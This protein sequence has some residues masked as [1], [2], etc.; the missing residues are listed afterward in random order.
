MTSIPADGRHLLGFVIFVVVMALAIFRPRGI[1]E[2]WAAVG[3]AAAMLALG[4]VSPPDLLRVLEETSGVLVFLLGMMAVAAVLDVAGVFEWAASVALRLSRCSGRRLLVSV[5]VLGAVVT[6]L[7]SLDVTVLML[8]PVVYTTVVAHQIDALPYLYACTFVANTGS[9][10]FPMSN[11]TNLLIVDGLKVP[12]WSYTAMM[13]VPDVAAVTTT[14]LVFLWVFRDRLPA[15][16][17]SMDRAWP[18]PPS[19]RF[20]RVA[21]GVCGLMLG[22][23]FA[24]G[25]AGWPLWPVA[26]G[27]GTVLV[28]AAWSIGRQDLR[29]LGRRIS[30]PL[31]PF[32][33]GIASTVRGIQHA[34][35]TQTLGRFVLGHAG[36]S[37]GSGLLIGT[38]SAL[39]A[40]VFT[41]VPMALVM[42]AALHQLPPARIGLLAGAVLAGTNIGPAMTPVGSLATML[43]LAF[44]R[45]Q[46]VN[47][48]V[49]DYL[50]V[51][52]LT[53]PCA[54]AAAL[55]TLFLQI[56]LWGT[57]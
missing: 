38:V 12:F 9:L 17:D 16:L 14:V 22:G 10:L 30:W 37:L 28:G 40:N 2:A 51:G 49:G 13:V 56:S 5:F 1:H 41:N 44:A 31:L 47:V 19:D 11:L 7:L 25:L 57:R 52:A 55:A 4:V 48:P 8:T 45:R 18:D 36:G 23:L 53:V 34:G 6:A 3:G 43:W 24:A 54:L 33:W 46:G 15:Q 29:A 42:L 50:R 35:L 32:V 26:L 27:A 20:F 21:V 39:G